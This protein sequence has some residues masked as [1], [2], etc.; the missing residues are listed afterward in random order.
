MR[1]RMKSLRLLHPLIH[2]ENIYRTVW[3]NKAPKKWEDL[4]LGFS[5]C[6]EDDNYPP[7]GR[8]S[9]MHVSQLTTCIS[10][11]RKDT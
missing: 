11:V 10:Q 3:M 8:G 7:R 2:P 4:K 6:V 5:H 9:F 1:L